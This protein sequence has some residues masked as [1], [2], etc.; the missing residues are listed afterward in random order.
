[1]I[2]WTALL[3]LAILR[4]FRYGCSHDDIGEAKYLCHCIG[5]MCSWGLDIRGAKLC[6]FCGCPCI[7]RI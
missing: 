3:C 5:I 7:V 4:P 2:E 1:M 6:F